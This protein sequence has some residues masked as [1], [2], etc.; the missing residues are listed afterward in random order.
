MSKAKKCDR[1]G[2][3]YEKNVVMK[4][5]CSVIGST[6]GGINTATKEGKTDEHFDLCDDCVKSLFKWKGKPEVKGGWI[7]IDD[8]YPDND[9]EVLVTIKIRC[10]NQLKRTDTARYVLD[11]LTGRS[12]W[13]TLG[14][15]VVGIG[16]VDPEIE[17]TAWME[18]PEPYK[19]DTRDE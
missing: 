14:H 6:I 15:G 7:P 13:E 18:L 17:V 10:K 12:L 9:R 4:S 8:V 19:E 3:F 2:K 16:R 11:T 5:K 1:C